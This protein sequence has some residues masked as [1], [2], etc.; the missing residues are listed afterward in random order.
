LQR[1]AETDLNSAGAVPSP[2]VPA[3]FPRGP[4]PRRQRP[5]EPVQS[6]VFDR[7]QHK[8]SLHLPVGLFVAIRD[9][10]DWV[11]YGAPGTVWRFEASQQGGGARNLE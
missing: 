6:G 4:S 11:N 10:H 7:K 5:T 2:I 3:V 9:G 1:V 8:S